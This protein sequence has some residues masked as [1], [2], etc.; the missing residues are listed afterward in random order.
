MDLLENLKMALLNF[1]FAIIYIISKMVLLVLLKNNLNYLI[2]SLSECFLKK[3][4]RLFLSWESN[5][6]SWQIIMESL[7]LEGE[8]NIKDIRN[9]LRLKKQLSYT[10]VKDLKKNPKA[11]KDGIL[12]LLRIFLSMKKNKIIMNQ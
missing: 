4:N 1:N 11:I 6:F 9:L 3:Y 7:S 2:D 8:S 10:A 5:I 12:K